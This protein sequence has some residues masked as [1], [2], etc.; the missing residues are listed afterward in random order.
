[1]KT[2]LVQITDCAYVLNAEN[3]KPPTLQQDGNELIVGNLA[4]WRTL[5]YF[6]H[7]RKDGD[8]EKGFQNVTGET[9]HLEMKV[10]WA[11]K[12]CVQVNNQCEESIT[13]CINITLPGIYIM[14]HAATQVIHL[15]F[16]TDDKGNSSGS[17]RMT[18]IWMLFL[19]SY[20]C[21][22]IYPS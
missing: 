3:A 9:I 21:W 2:S 1:M 16:Y 4:G 6:Q 11:S 12:A 15:I 13:D 14:K 5:E 8:T 7:S 18:P 10:E 19:V 22:N 20:F 17:I